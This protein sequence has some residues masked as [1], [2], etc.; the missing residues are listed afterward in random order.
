LFLTRYDF[1]S[2]AQINPEVDIWK[3]TTRSK[4]KQII[5]RILA[6]AKYIENTRSCKL[7]PVSL[8]PEIKSYLVKN[9]EDYVLSC[10]DIT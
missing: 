1:I 2:G 9:K 10:L 5:F 8:T 7:I 3:E 4:L 6:E